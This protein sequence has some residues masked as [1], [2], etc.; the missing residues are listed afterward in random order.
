[1]PEVLV[2]YRRSPTSRERGSRAPGVSTRLMRSL[3][4][5]HRELY[6]ANLEDAL[7]GM[8]ERLA[9]AGLT[10]ERIYDHPAVRALVR[11]RSF[12]RRKPAA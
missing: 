12:L 9:A 10:L 1:V 2:Y 4:G 7:G 3:V 8:Y 11:L 5:K 6:V